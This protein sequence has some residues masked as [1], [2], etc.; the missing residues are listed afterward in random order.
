[1]HDY[2]TMQGAG[3]AVHSPLAHLIGAQDWTSTPLGPIE[4]SPQSLR[5]A[6]S[7]CLES[8]FPI[9]I[10]W[11]PELVMLYNEPYAQLLG[12]KHPG[13][14]G[15]RGVDCFPEIWHL[16]GPMLAG[17]RDG[18]EATWSPDQLVELDRS[19]VVE[20][21]YFTFG[22]S[23]IRD[24][25]GAVNGIFTAVAETTSHVIG[26]RRLR[27]L[28][29]LTSETSGART[30]A[31][32]CERAAAVFRGSV[33]ISFSVAY[34]FDADMTVARLVATSDLKR[35]GKSIAPRLVDLTNDN[36]GSWPLASIAGADA[37]IV[38]DEI[39]EHIGDHA[40]TEGLSRRA[41]LLPLQ[42]GTEAPVGA[43][44]L[45]VNERRP[46][47]DDYVAFLKLVARQVGAA[48]AD[49]QRAEAERQRSE[50]L[51]ELDR[52]KTL[53]FTNVSHELRT[54]LTLIL[55][56]LEDLLAEA[57]QPAGRRED[58]ELI[59][60]NAL[61]LLRL[62][63][64]L[65][66]F[67]RA[68]S[69]R[70]DALFQPTDLA[71][72][73]ADLA[74]AFRSAVEAAGLRL[75]VDC[76][77][78]GEP[79]WVDRESWEK[80]VLNL[81]SNAL[82]FTFAGEIAVS[83]HLE[84]GDVVLRVRDTGVGVPEDDLPRLFERFHRIKDAAARS[85]EGSGIGLALVDELT[86]LHGGGVFVASELGTGST[87]TVRLPRGRAHLDA[88]KRGGPDGTAARSLGAAPYV[89]EAFR[90]LPAETRP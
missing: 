34:L 75:A 5:T 64:T 26:A 65:L 42:R 16:I 78:L 19:G 76:P 30:P 58:L 29:Q 25:T 11:G 23:A 27:I 57:E 21:C 54:P 7:I 24:E 81:L 38:I 80:I 14:L 82:K 2:A 51:A 17:V 3:D 59:R 41:L 61:R 62:V 70:I 84:E 77:S 28:R 74:S 72:V 86:R 15:Q 83:L 68:E 44:V 85:H 13:A 66:D 52:A 6:L 12:N 36:P 63:N 49:A 53:F 45:G 47:D 48:I 32:V 39:V 73:T 33:A 60:R 89:E 56:P 88:D 22:F 1:M 37:P 43:L 71:A 55:S 20:E 35:R 69:G 31:E 40:A 10:W 50:A 87:F 9:L 18:G 8:R 67:S 90:W 4:T 79:I 46:V